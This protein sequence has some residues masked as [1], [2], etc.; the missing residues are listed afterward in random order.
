MIVM[1]D[2][3][4]TDIALDILRYSDLPLPPTSYIHHHHMSLL[5]RKVKGV[6]G[7]E[8]NIMSRGW[9]TVKTIKISHV[10]GFTFTK[11][12]RMR[13]YLRS[14][15]CNSISLSLTIHSMRFLKKKK[16]SLNRLQVSTRNYRPQH[17]AKLVTDHFDRSKAEVSHLQYLLPHCGLWLFSRNMLAMTAKKVVSACK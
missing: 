10:M 3:E 4:A 8:E 2:W 9:S 17:R 6:R 5:N 16:I 14:K 1:F 13:N 15:D 12:K 11:K 7:E